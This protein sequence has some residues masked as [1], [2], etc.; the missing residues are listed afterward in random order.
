[1]HSGTRRSFD[2]RFQSGSC[3]LWLGLVYVCACVFLGLVYF[4]ARVGGGGDAVAI[5]ADDIRD[6]ST[7]QGRYPKG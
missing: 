6:V 2:R 1:M 7:S 4:G 3:Q 5:V